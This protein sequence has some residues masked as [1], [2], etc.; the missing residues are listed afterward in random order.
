MISLWETIKQCTGG[1]L[2]SCHDSTQQYE[3]VQDQPGYPPPP[4]ATY[5]NA[6]A[7]SIMN[8]EP[9]THENGQYNGGR[10]KFLMLKDINAAS[11]QHRSSCPGEVSSDVPWQVDMEVHVKDLPKL[12]REGLHW[13]EENMDLTSSCF[14]LVTQNGLFHSRTISLGWTLPPLPVERRR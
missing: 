8:D 10:V 13:S 2:G 11:Y 3:R 6:N 1:C 14:Q 7:K 12:M 4:Y 9:Q 5:T